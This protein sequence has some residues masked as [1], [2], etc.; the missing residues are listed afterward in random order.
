MT[1][2][3]ELNEAK[4]RIDAAKAQADAEVASRDE[5]IVD[6]NEEVDALEADVTAQATE[7][8]ELEARIAEL[9][10]SQPTPTPAVPTNVVADGVGD[11]NDPGFKWD[12]VT[13]VTNYDVEHKVGSGAATVVRVATTSFRLN[14]V[15]AGTY[16]FRVRSVASDGTTVSEY[17]TAVTVT[18][19]SAPAPLN[20]VE[21]TLVTKGSTSRAI[22]GANIAFRGTDQIII[23]TTAY[24]P[25]TGQNR[26]GVEVA[27]VNNV[28]TAVRDRLTA[29][30]DPGAMPIPAN[31][32][33]LSGHDAGVGDTA[34]GWLRTNATVGSTLVLS[35]GGSGSTPPSG[36]VKIMPVG[37]SLT[38]VDDSALGFKG[39]LLDSL[40]AEEFTIDYV[41]SK[42]ANGPAGLKDKNHEGVPGAQNSTFLGQYLE[43]TPLG[44]KVTTHNPDVLTY[45]VGVNDLWSNV[46]VATAVDRVRQVLT[47]VF[48][49]KSSVKVIV[50][51]I[52]KMGVS[53]NSNRAA[54]NSGIDTVAAE[55]KTAGRN[56]TVADLSNTLTTSDLQADGI[57]WTSGGHTKVAAALL[58][59][60]KAVIN[61]TTTPPVEEPDTWP[62]KS[63]KRS[64]KSSPRSLASSA[65]S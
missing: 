15:A 25:N 18:V 16:S 53:Q 49:A 36:V 64:R 43:T 8:E 65:R 58:P 62:P 34:G 10:A 54:Y 27:V 11:G 31:G 17:S 59:V 41:G 45:L 22:N 12:A 44:Q 19:A 3:D 29:A 39:I 57:H 32:Y 28:V 52:P 51:K 37:D 55:F 33:V 6:L 48:A 50:C 20:P 13:G 38:A 30:T 42:T 47:A 61:G 4:A 46:P 21:A 23:Y 26:Y 63:R 60:V 5:E 40:T 56:I 24:G 35:K 9:E 2:S 14:N 7:I 1:Y